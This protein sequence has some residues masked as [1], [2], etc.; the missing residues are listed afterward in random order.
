MSGTYTAHHSAVLLCLDEVERLQMK[1]CSLKALLFCK[2]IMSNIDLQFD[3][4]KR[5]LWGKK[6]TGPAGK[7]VLNAN[8]DTSTVFSLFV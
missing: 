1:S 8:P 3:L 6:P 5:K 7:F 2:M 4:G